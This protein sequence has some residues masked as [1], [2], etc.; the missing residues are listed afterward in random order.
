MEHGIGTGDQYSSPLDQYNFTALVFVIEKDTNKSVPITTFVVGDAGPA[1]FTTT[2]VELPTTNNFTYDAGNGPTTVEV[3]ST[4]V[5]ATVKH[6]NRARSLTFSMFVI[7][8]VL[9]L[10]SVVIALIVLRRQGGLSDGIAFL[11]LTV[12]LSTPTIR[13][14]YVGSPP[15]GILLGTHQ[16]FRRLPFR[17]FT[18]P[19]RH[20]RVLSTNADSTGFRHNSIVCFRDA[21]HPAGQ[22]YYLREKGDLTR[23]FSAAT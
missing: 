19:S 16:H 8:W 23:S 4:T 17:G 21:A 12:I 11:P 1:D 18:L 13:S 20:A 3:N 5:F 14:L 10:C 9:T 7:N 6:S 15:F 2:S 22:R